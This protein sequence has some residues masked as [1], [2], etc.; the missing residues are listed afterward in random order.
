MEYDEQGN[1]STSNSRTNARFF[2]KIIIHGKHM[3]FVYFII[4]SLTVHFHFVLI[5]KLVN[6]GRIRSWMC[7]NFA[8]NVQDSVATGFCR[9]LARMCQASGMAS[10]PE[11]LQAM[12]AHCTCYFS[13]VLVGYNSNSLTI[14]YRNLLWSLFFQL[15]MC[16]LIKWSEL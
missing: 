8:R 6:G 2:L 14:N 10:I 16:V 7:V 9:E 4:S 13:L 15:Y 3:P 12:L 1:D 11:M 5:Q